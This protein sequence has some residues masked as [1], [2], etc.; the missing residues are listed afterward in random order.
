VIDRIDGRVE[1]TARGIRRPPLRLDAAFGPIREA[2]REPV[3]A[4]ISRLA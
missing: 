2:E 1:R 4:L 3:G